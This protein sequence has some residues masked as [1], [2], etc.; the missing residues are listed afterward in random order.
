MRIRAI[1]LTCV[2]C[3][4]LSLL[5]VGCVIHESPPPRHV[6]VEREVVEVEPPPAERIYIYEVGYPPGTYRC[7]DYYYCGGHRYEHDV[8][9]TRV[10][11][12]NIHE[13][14]YVNVEENRRTAH[15]IEHEHMVQYH[16]QQ[17]QLHVQEHAQEH[18]LHA[19][20]HQQ[21]AQQQQ[22]HQYSGQS[23]QPVHPVYQQSAKS[24]TSKKKDSKDKDKDRD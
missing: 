22:Q 10:V 20:E 5:S 14:R 12:V 4:A 17:H 3:G 19:Q 6:I 16:E 1:G 21:H 9:V 24:E 11:N 13:H 18:Q 7:G 8:F 23:G 2:A 15:E